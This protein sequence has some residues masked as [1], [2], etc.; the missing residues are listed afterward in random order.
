MHKL[1]E[2]IQDKGN[3]RSSHSEMLE[4]SNHLTVRGGIDQRSSIMSSQRST[5]LK[6]WR[7]MFGVEHVMF[8]QEIDDILLLR[9]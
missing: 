1:G 4:A 8:A 3:I 9:E 6:R 2:F 5:Y 7:D